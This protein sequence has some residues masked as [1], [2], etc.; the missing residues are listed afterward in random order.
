MLTN[1]DKIIEPFTNLVNDLANNYYDK[2]D[3]D[4][5]ISQTW[6][7]IVVEELPTED[8]Q[9]NLIYLKGPIWELRDRYEEWIYTWTPWTRTLIWE[10]TVDLTDYATKDFCKKT[11]YPL[12]W[13]IFETT[14][15]VWPEN[16]DISNWFLHRR[17]FAAGSTQS[18]TGSLYNWAAFWVKL[19]GTASFQH[20]TYANW[21][22]G[23]AKNTAVMTFSWRTWLRFAVNTWSWSDVTP[24]MYH[25][26]LVDQTNYSSLQTEAK[27][28]IWAINELAAKFEELSWKVDQIAEHLNLNS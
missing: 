23:W 22:F 10:T 4:N 21:K 25:D 26:V 7:F 5:L 16:S 18:V 28:I 19:D 2:E 11:Y 8:I 17:A 12:A 9:R 14:V 3:I 24:D 20:K 27:D 6:G 15:T 13:W 1:S